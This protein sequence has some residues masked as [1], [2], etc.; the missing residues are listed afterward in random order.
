[1]TFLQRTLWTLA[2]IAALGF[3]WLLLWVDY[4]YDTAREVGDA[5]R[6]EFE[7]TDHT[8]MIRTQDDF[9]G[10]WMLIFF[11]FSNCPDVC[12]TTLAEVAVVMDR[13]GDDADTVQPLFISIDPERDTPTALAKY[14]PMFDANI[15]GLTGTSG[16]IER[17]AE[18]FP[19]F[20]EKI[21][22]AATQDGYTMSH[23]S[24]LLLFGPN[25]DLVTT[26]AYGTSAEEILVDLREFLP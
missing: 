1:M 9:A 26:W 22:E 8:G 5:I 7:L 13:L 6:A 2:G 19:I 10:R 18:N 23:T 16:Q 14:V 15:I 21:E 4:R 3:L 17:T 20:Y 11:G 25:A 12:P 24:H